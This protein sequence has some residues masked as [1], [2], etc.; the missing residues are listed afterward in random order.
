M[1][2]LIHDRNNFLGVCLNLMPQL[3]GRRVE[4]QVGDVDIE[5]CC[6]QE[7]HILQSL[8]VGLRFGIRSILNIFIGGA[9]AVH[10]IFLREIAEKV[11]ERC[12]SIIDRNGRTPNKTLSL[13]TENVSLRGVGVSVCK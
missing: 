10:A 9:V 3:S 6:T 12:K 5:S 4:V 7:Q 8:P 11:L 1:N 13:S 2:G